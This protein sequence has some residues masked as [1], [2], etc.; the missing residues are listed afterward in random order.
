MHCTRVCSS[1]AYAV[2]YVLH[3]L[4]AYVL[5]LLHALYAL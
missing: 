1:D 2:C 3:L 4:Y 5:Y